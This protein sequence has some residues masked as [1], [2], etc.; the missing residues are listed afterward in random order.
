MSV[1]F[2]VPLNKIQVFKLKKMLADDEQIFVTN[3]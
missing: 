2:E 1:H 3:I